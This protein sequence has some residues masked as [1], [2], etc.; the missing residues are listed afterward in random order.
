MDDLKQFR[1]LH[2]KTPGHPEL[3]HTDGIEVTTG[4]LGQ[5]IANAVGL[6]IAEKHLAATFNKDNFDIVNNNIWSE[7]RV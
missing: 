4:P 5:G 7:F 3:H 2:S 1:Q 6:A